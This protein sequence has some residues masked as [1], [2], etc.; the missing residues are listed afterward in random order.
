MCSMFIIIHTNAATSNRGTVHEPVYGATRAR[1]AYT[2]DEKM[3]N[4][5][6]FSFF[7]ETISEI[8]P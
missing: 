1:T 7:F 3:N 8:T 4:F 2:D 5:Y 6:F